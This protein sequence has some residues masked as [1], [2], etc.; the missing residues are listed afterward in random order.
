MDRFALFDGLVVVLVIERGVASLGECDEN[1]ETR[2]REHNQRTIMKSCTYLSMSSSQKQH[3]WC[4]KGLG[5]CNTGLL[6]E[7]AQ[8]DPGE[9]GRREND[10]AG[11]GYGSE[12]EVTDND[13]S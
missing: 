5:G 12:Y 9:P 13:L 7:F 10:A 8:V 3:C 2:I 1:L 4:Y 11:A 6:V